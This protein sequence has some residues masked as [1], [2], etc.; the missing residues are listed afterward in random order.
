MA[1]VVTKKIKNKNEWM[2][3]NNTT[4]NNNSKTNEHIKE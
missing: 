4:I 1:V 2:N 3:A